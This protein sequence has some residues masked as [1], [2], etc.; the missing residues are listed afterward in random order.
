MRVFIAIDI[1]EDICMRLTD[2]QRKLRPLTTSA[3]WV[4]AESA[5]LTLK[6]LGEISETRTQ[7]VHEALTGLTW[8]P[9][10]VSVKGIG[11]FPGRRSPR[12]FWA[13]LEAPTMASLAEKIDTR[14]EWLGFEK[15]KRAFRP[16]ITMARAKATPLDSALLAASASFEQQDFGVFTVDRC[17]LYQ[18]TLKPSGSVH[19]KLKEYRLTSDKPEKQT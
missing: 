16:H 6:F 17:F 13:G 4:S 7:Q 3:R 11:F 8:K 5:H 2:M 14:M 19:T 15:E 10:E 18:S 12:V 9:F 1:P